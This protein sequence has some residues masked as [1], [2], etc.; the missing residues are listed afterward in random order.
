MAGSSRTAG[1]PARRGGLPNALFLVEAA[2]QLPGPLCG[3]ADQVTVVLPWG[4]LLRA[5]SA[6][7]PPIVNAIGD[8]LGAGGELTLLLSELSRDD[9]EGLARAYEEAGF[10]C[11]E[12]RPAS[13]QDVSDLSSGWAKRL[14]IPG[15][16]PAWIIRL[17]R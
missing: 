2:E 1:R 13:V 17:R 5:V 16:R 10:E 12:I 6:P 11:L 8:M 9:V 15:S 7:E 3:Q 4:S 14:R